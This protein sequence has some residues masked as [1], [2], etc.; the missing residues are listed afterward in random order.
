M[1][2]SFKK[3]KLV[4][5]YLV[6]FTLSSQALALSSAPNIFCSKK[7]N[8]PD[9]ISGASKCLACHSS[10]PNLN[11]YGQDVQSYLF[12][13]KGYDKSKFTLYLNGAIDYLDKLDSDS[14]SFINTIE[15]EKSTKPYDESSIP[16]IPI[17][18]TYENEFAYKRMWIAFCGRSPT[19]ESMKA[20]RNSSNQKEIIHKDLSQC[21]KSNFWLKEALY[22]LADKK[23]R[24]TKALGAEG[25]IVVADYK[26]DYRLFSYIMSEDHDARELLTADY[27]IEPDGSKTTRT[28]LKEDPVNGTFPS[29]IIV[30]DVGQPL[31]H[32][33]RAGMLTTQWFLTSNTMFTKIPRVTAAQAYRAYLGLDIAKG[34]GLFSV[35]EELI[36]Y[37]KK[38][39]TA[40]S[41]AVCHKTLDRITYP[42][43][44][45]EGIFGGSVSG[46]YKPSR[47]FSELEGSGYILG[48]PTTGLKDWAQ[49]AANSDE[50]K[51]M[52]TKLFLQYAIDQKITSDNEDFE[53]LWQSIPGDGYS[54]NKLI[55]RIVDTMTFGAP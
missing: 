12:K 10:V 33:Y 25:S 18:R 41:C 54:I 46:T 38:G 3:L 28:I 6:S 39:I 36:D 8:A 55:H 43:I 49:K 23:I 40:P 20:F 37:D 42:F 29:N 9:C 21:L 27:H 44:P 31:P 7:P 24:P 15:L 16:E 13:Q 2:R 52:L 47:E 48:T 14:D 1:N 35:E 17:V 34:D 19:Y 45:Y 22:R 4:I 32:Q 26:W 51:I 30:V 5:L 11:L 53:E 50:F